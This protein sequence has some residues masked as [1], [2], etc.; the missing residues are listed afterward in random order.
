MDFSK[1]Y[2]VV[3]E[4]CRLRPNSR[5]RIPVVISTPAL[6]DQ[7]PSSRSFPNWCRTWVLL[8]I[9]FR[10]FGTTNSI[11]SF[12]FLCFKKLLLLIV[13]GLK[14]IK[15]KTFKF[16]AH[17]FQIL[18]WTSG[19]KVLLKEKILYSREKFK[20]SYSRCFSKFRL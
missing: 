6:G 12:L 13:V 1:R 7:P 4:V 9:P 18:V 2:C 19:K 17:V 16:P 10:G 14:F 15:A 3:R 5:N 11:C 8:H 20:C